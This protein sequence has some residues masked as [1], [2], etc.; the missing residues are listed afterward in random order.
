MKRNKTKWVV[1]ALFIL[2][3]C[4]PFLIVESA[5]FSRTKFC[6]LCH[7]M[8]L[9]YQEYIKS[10]HFNNSSGVRAECA[11]CHIPQQFGPKFVR[12]ATSAKELYVHLTGEL[13][14]KEKFEDQR[15][16]LA[17]RIWADMKASDSRE[18][19]T[20]HNQQA[21]VFAQF[22]K[23][24]EAQ[25]M[26]KGLKENQ[27]C[28]DCHKG[29]THQMPNLA[30]GYKKLY[31]EL[32]AATANPKI[33]TESVYPLTTVF[34]YSGKEGEREERVLAATRLT[35]VENSGSWLKVRADGWQQDGVD[36]LI[37][38]LQGKRIFAV[39]F[40]KPARG[41]PKVHSTMT[42]HDTE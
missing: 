20:C 6:L 16:R 31:E 11:S 7:E 13:D 14:T 21:F 2:A 33:T 8:N 19:R 18:C 23:P 12:K 9:P 5:Y 4:I 37:Y 42:D 15:T 38:E 32:E 28:I 26:Q 36:A 34:C 25:R 3:F 30:S 17:K 10:S 27:T 39:A 24:K 1:L 29:K 40:D 22:K 41:K 35:V